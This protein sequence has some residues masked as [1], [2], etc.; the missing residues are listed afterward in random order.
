MGQIILY[1]LISGFFA[2]IGGILVLWRYQLAMKI[3][4][5]LIA[6][7][8]GAF[9]GVSFLDLL[10]EAVEAV[11]EPHDIFIAF[12]VGFFLFFVLERL[13]MRHFH[14]L[15]RTEDS[16]SEHTASLPSLVILG[17]SIHNFLDGVAIALAFVADPSLGLVTAFAVAAH[18]VP[19]EIGDFIILLDRGWSKMKVLA[20]NV[21]QSL[22]AVI[23]AIIGYFGARMFENT[24]PFLLAGTAGIFVYIAASNL[25]PE[26]QDRAKHS[27]TYRILIAFLL[28]L[29]SIG[30]LVSVAHG[31]E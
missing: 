12:L 29:V 20:V 9:L 15:H 19:Q 2:L 18:E 16:H 7:A 24:L 31:G 17:D 1:S 26:L 10:P 30:A 13:I 3:V 21:G 23:G 22:L 4:I 11:D 25:I 14:S 6:F 8:A 27:Q 5:P 28:G